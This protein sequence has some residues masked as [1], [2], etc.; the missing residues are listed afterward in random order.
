MH[1]HRFGHSASEKTTNRV[2]GMRYWV[3]K[4]GARLAGATERREAVRL[5]SSL[6]G[7]VVERIAAVNGSTGGD[8]MV[9]ES[10]GSAVK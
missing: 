9:V 3:V 6:G 5:A 8:G 10:R 7:Y 4:D 1:D 2:A